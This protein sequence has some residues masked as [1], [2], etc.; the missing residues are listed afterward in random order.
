[1]ADVAA[2]SQSKEAAEYLDQCFFH[3]PH[4]PARSRLWPAGE[5][6]ASPWLRR[7]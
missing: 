4:S 7:T 3:A 5:G 1:M 6:A 2:T